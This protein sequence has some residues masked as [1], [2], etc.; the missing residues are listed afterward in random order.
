M[1]MSSSKGLPPPR[2]QGTVPP[3]GAVAVAVPG[4]GTF[5][6][7]A[8]GVLGV[9]AAG[10]AGLGGIADSAGGCPLRRRVQLLW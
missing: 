2:L 4:A 9:G 8:G 1:Q 7:A 3:F 6:D 10:A 5:V